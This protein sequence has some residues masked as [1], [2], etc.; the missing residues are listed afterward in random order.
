MLIYMFTGDII[1]Q[2]VVQENQLRAG[3]GIHTCG[4]QNKEIG[5]STI[6]LE[7]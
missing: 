7:H 2:F 4:S 1:I 6:V 3:I 5:L